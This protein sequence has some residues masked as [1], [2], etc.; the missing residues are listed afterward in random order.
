[1]EKHISYKILP[2]LKLIVCNYLGDISIRDVM[3]TT[4]AFVKDPQFNP[5]FNVLL[6]F[7]NSSAIGFRL[8]IVDYVNFFKNNVTLKNK[9]Q[10]GIAYSTPNQEFLLKVYKGFGKFMNLEI[11]N[12]KQIEPCLTWLH[13]SES[14]AFFVMQVLDSMK[15]DLDSDS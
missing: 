1:M 4:L 14:E 2:D 8:D 7:R 6:D 3:E 10:V 11:E 15:S 9:V 5:D 12:F 13:F